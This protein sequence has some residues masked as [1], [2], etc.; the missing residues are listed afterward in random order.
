MGFELPNFKFPPDL[1]DKYVPLLYCAATHTKFKTD[2]KKVKIE[3]P[4]ISDLQGSSRWTVYSINSLKS[5]DI[6]KEVV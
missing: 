5:Q 2:L 6:L 3:N 4:Y 1:Q